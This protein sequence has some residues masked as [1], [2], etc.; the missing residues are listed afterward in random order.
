MNTKR[1]A[2]LLIIVAMLAG[3][4]AEPFEP[5]GPTDNVGHTV[6]YIVDH[7]E[8]RATLQNEQEWDALLGSFMDWALDGRAVT[9][10]NAAL[11]RKSAPTAKRRETFSTSDREKMKEWMK[12]K[13]KQGKTVTITY[14]KQTGKYSGTAYASAPQGSESRSGTFGYRDAQGALTLFT[15]DTLNRRLLVTHSSGDARLQRYVAGGV[16]SYDGAS[17]TV[18]L[19]GVGGQG[20][21]WRVV[22]TLALG[23]TLTLRSRSSLARQEAPVKMPPLGGVR[24]Y[25]CHA[26]ECTV[27]MHVLSHSVELASPLTVRAEAQM[28]VVG[29]SS[30]FADG[31]CTWRYE[32]AGAC[33][34]LE[35]TFA[36]GNR[37]AG[38]MMVGNPETDDAFSL[39]WQGREYTFD[40]M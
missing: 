16:H 32:D 26:Q 37:V 33:R 13:E 40:L 21:P 36:D 34:Q 1:T 2:L 14:D 20:G 10:Y 30:L 5:A 3:C 35:I 8:H 22:A 38:L 27:V 6:V 39:V 4:S 18:V 19:P 25:V 9:F 11:S 28:A 31:A 23:D 17:G 15:L 29:E 24:L 12:E 7:E